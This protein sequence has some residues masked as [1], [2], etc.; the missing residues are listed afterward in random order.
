MYIGKAVD[1]VND[2]GQPLR[3]C[4]SA[5]AV[6]DQILAD[7]DQRMGIAVDNSM[8]EHGVAAQGAVI[9]LVV[10]DD[11]RLVFGQHVDHRP[12]HAVV[13]VPQDADMPGADEALHDRGERM[14]R[15]DDRRFPG[16]MRH[17]G[18][19]RAD[20]VVVGPVEAVEPFF[21]LL[22]GHRIVSRHDGAVIELADQRRVV[23]ASVGV[24][25]EP[26]EAGKH[27][28]RVERRRQLA[29]HRLD[30]DVIGDMALE[31]RRRQAEAAIFVR[32]IP[33]GVISQK[34]D[35]FLAVALAYTIVR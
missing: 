31:L 12:R 28:R 20:G 5:G 7:L 25:Q 18:N 22:G 4:E 29:R 10:A 14:H 34:H 1:G 13:A 27:S 35:A 16:G 26:R 3:P 32:H 2:R 15:D 21:P 33:A 24:D 8:A 30:A 19:H 9:G 23:L 6:G 17:R 11:E